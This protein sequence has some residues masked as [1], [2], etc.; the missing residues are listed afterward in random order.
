MQFQSAV[1]EFNRFDRKPGLDAIYRLGLRAD[2][3]EPAADGKRLQARFERCPACN[4]IDNGINACAIRERFDGARQS[5]ISAVD[6][7]ICAHRLSKVELVLA[8]I[9]REYAST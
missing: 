4:D 3:D 2:D 9:R 1:Q 8:D 6:H 5:R 7:F